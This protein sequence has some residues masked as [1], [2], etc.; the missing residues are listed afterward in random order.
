[1]RR[2]DLTL[3]NQHYQTAFAQR[4]P[5]AETWFIATIHR[6]GLAGREGNKIAFSA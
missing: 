1:L 5:L 2:G 6:D 4:Q 3:R